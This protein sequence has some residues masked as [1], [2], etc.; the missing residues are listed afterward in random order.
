MSRNLMRWTPEVD[1]HILIAMSKVI[2]SDQYDAIMEGLEPYG[3]SFTIS[4]LK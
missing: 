2:K 1:Q 4:A 3:Y